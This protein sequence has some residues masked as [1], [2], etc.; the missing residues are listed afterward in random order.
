MNDTVKFV[1]DNW[2]TIYNIGATIWG[3]GVTIASLWTAY[4]HKHIKG[5]QGGDAT[6]GQVA[7]IR[8]E[9]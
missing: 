6:T 4:Q 3:A 5:L 7:K 9:R 8:G 1:V 2:A